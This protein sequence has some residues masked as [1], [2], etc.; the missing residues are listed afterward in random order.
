[1]AAVGV[2]VD[3][4]LYGWF[5][6]A[7]RLS[8]AA[9]ITGGVE[10]T[11]WAPYED[12]GCTQEAWH[13]VLADGASTGDLYHDEPLP[14]AISSLQAL[15]DAGH[16]VHLVTARGQLAN[17]HLIR[18][19]TVRWIFNHQVP[20]D[21]L[22]FSHVKSIVRCDYFI[23]DN[24]DNIRDVTQSRTVGLLVDRPWNQEQSDGT[25]VRVPDVAAAVKLVL[26]IDTI[27]RAYPRRY[28]AG[29]NT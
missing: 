25:Y 13:E 9:G 7:H 1:M 8:V 11:S 23:D 21:T 27:E 3:D 19:H 22:T 10:P 18:E 14:D 20:H 16:T 24:L 6:A 5:A 17:G 15:K 29:L 4:V 2:D 12:Y 26:D 28:V